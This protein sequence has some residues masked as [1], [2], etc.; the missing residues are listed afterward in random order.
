LAPIA[1]PLGDPY[2]DPA[3]SGDVRLSFRRSIY[4]PGSGV[5][6]GIPRE[7]LNEITAW[8]DASQVYGSDADTAASLRTFVG[9]RL[10][11]SDGDLLPVDEAG[12][13]RAGDVR[14][15]EQLGLIAMHTVF[16][17]EHNRIVASMA[18]M[19]PTLSDE[20]L[21]Q[22]ARRI[23][24]A[25][26]Q[27][28]TFRE[29]LPALLGPDPLPPYSGY[30]PTADAPIANEFS[31]AAFRLGHSLLNT[32][33]LR[34]DADGHPIAAGNIALREAFFAPDRIRD[35]GG[36]EPILRGLAAQAAQNV[37]PFVVDDVRNFL[38]GPPG[39]GGF[40][41]ASLNIQRGRDHGL[42]SYNDMRRAL[43]L[44]PARR[45]ADISSN[46]EIRNR[47]AS[48]YVSVEDIDLWIG[49]LAEDHR[50]GALVGPLIATILTHQFEN[51]R[52]GDR[53]WYQRILTPL[54][55]AIVGS[56]RLADVIRRNTAI[57][58]ELDRDAFR[59]D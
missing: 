55:Q 53:F 8:I 30:R 10:A 14:A 46:R 31:T 22:R 19:Q 7:Q 15:N 43:G 56:T 23:V 24:G 17:R 11:V 57:G 44:R 25:L 50:P 38:F 40:D 1:I 13:F 51:L 32:T 42:P 27:A 9:G 41:L 47:L 45:F 6:D 33:M 18:R 49:G 34:L 28:I 54:E 58:S 21:Y 35:E 16:V 20:Q 4:D 59:V 29:F 48:V 2:F 3:G 12:F 52:D 36:I 39:A 5:A 26:L 37:D